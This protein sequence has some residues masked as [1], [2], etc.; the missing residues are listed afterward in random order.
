MF[1]LPMVMGAATLNVRTPLDTAVNAGL[2]MTRPVAK[3]FKMVAATLP[4]FDV[5]LLLKEVALSVKLVTQLAPLKYCTVA[6]NGNASRSDPYALGN[7][8]RPLATSSPA[9]TA[10]VRSEVVLSVS[11]AR[12]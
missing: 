11:T 3:P 8:I 2:T 1:A 10:P 9:S 5:K 12:K 6:V 4:E 7:L